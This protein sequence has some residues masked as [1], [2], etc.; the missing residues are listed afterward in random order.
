MLSTQHIFELF[1]FPFL[2]LLLVIAFSLRAPVLHCSSGVL[3]RRHG[4]FNLE[5][6]EADAIILYIVF[7][8]P[9]GHC[10]PSGNRVEDSIILIF[11]ANWL[12]LPRCLELV[13]CP[14]I[15]PMFSLSPL[16]CNKQ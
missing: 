9:A 8:S 6:S 13:H 4:P 1:M 16:A 14:G 10:C 7:S 11:D 5:Q 3:G 12:I 15:V 2:E